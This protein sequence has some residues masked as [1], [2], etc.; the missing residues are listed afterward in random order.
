MDSDR[1]N[2]A[3]Q[4]LKAIDYGN[5]SE[6]EIERRIDRILDNELNVPIHTKVNLTKVNLC[7]SLLWQLYTHGRVAYENHM[8]TSKKVVE[9][10]YAKHK[11][12]KR[13]VRGGLRIIALSLL[14]LIMLTTTQSKQWFE[15]T[16]TED[17]QQY[18]VVYHEVDGMTIAKAIEE[19]NSFDELSTNSA[20]EVNRF[21]GF[22]YRFP[23]S[24]GASYYVLNYH[25]LIMPEF[26]SILCE[27]RDEQSEDAY[28]TLQ[29]ELFTS[30]EEA[31]IQYEQDIEGKEVMISNVIVYKYTNIGKTR[32]IW[33]K[34]NKIYKLSNNGRKAIAEQDIQNI[35]EWEE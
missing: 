32:Y 26:I 24:I 13:L 19:H 16:S 3:D 7:N 10:Y 2:A 20:D 29:V 34:G 8:E 11:H 27:Y 5:I 30:E 17:E 4:I 22:S 28:I 33:A 35:I 1:H 31:R 9:K 12:K 14:L 25:V 23:S 18:T 15:K 21:L 6:S